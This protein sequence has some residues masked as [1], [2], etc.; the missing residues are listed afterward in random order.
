MND[1]DPK[2]LTLSKT[3]ISYNI[4]EIVYP[5]QDQNHE[6][7]SGT[8]SYRVY[9]GVLHPSWVI[10]GTA[11]LELMTQKII[12]VCHAECRNYN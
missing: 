2:T 10:K 12:F 11:D 1:W 7:S 9:I 3:R 8:S 6:K 4:M 5:V